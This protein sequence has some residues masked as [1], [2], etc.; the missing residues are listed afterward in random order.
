M[1]SD[2]ED[3]MSDQMSEDEFDDDSLGELGEFFSELAGGVDW[4]SVPVMHAATSFL[5]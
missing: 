2:D 3:F 5:L 1:S 4:H